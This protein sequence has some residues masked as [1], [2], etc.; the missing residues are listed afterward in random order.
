MI[1]DTLP[2]PIRVVV[3]AATGL[4]RCEITSAFDADFDVT[5]VADARAAEEA[6][7]DQPHALIVVADD[8]YNSRPE[9]L[10]HRVRIASR[11]PYRVAAMFLTA[12]SGELD[13]PSAYHAGADDIGRWPLE[14]DMFRARVRSMVRVATLEAGIGR[15]ARSG[16]ADL[17]DLQEAL[18]QTIHL[19]NNAVAGISG[20]AQLAALTRATDEGGLIPVCLCESRKMTLILAALHGL[21][22]SIGGAEDED[23][24]REIVV[25]AGIR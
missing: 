4:I 3:V 16:V 19:V 21:S 6:T 10:V 1:T 12:H 5:S 24:M 2:D 9:D 7:A 23:A 15:L 17:A 11:S 20:R 8:L 13:L 18:S 22:E 25:G 14:A